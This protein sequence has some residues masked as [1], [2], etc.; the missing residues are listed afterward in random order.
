MTDISLDR[1]LCS[2]GE[3]REI[4]NLVEFTGDGRFPSEHANYHF[5]SPLVF[6]FL[7]LFYLKFIYKFYIIRFCIYHRIIINIL[8]K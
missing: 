7:F 6:H 2:I 8:N 5:K 1:T 3:A 4:C